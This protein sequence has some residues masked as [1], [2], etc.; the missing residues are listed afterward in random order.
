MTTEI[1]ADSKIALV[2]VA[3]VS[4]AVTMGTALMYQHRAMQTMEAE[5]QDAVRK[6]RRRLRNKYRQTAEYQRK[7]Q[8]HEERKRAREANLQEMAY[9]NENDEMVITKVDVR[10]TNGATPDGFVRVNLDEPIADFKVTKEMTGEKFI[11]N[12]ENVNKQR[13]QKAEQSRNEA[14]EAS[15]KLDISLHKKLSAVEVDAVKGDKS[16]DVIIDLNP[17][18]YNKKNDN[19]YMDLMALYARTSLTDKSQRRA[20]AGKANFL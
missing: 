15:Q 6:E 10:K 1:V 20:S 4:I 17:K 14:R 18:K 11:E 12:L 8:I 9:F 7:K 2:T 16:E 3:A 19:I 13:A 5:T